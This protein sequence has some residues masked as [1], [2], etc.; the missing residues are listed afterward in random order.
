M[1]IKFTIDDAQAAAD[2]WRFN[3]GPGA[4]CAVLD[5]TPVQIRP[6]LGDFERK[7]Y[8][9][10]TLMTDTLRR[11]G[12]AFRVKYRGDAPAAKIPV[13]RLGLVRV[14][15]GGPWTKPGVPMAAR[16]R[17]TH[18]IAVAGSEIF[19]I[20]AMCVGGWMPARDW[21]HALAPWLIREAV[22]RGD[23]T[24]WPTHA[25]ELGEGA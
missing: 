16:Y 6:L 10:P 23:G 15:W 17:E 8:T 13:L 18:W 11:A 4:L 3:C 14:Q 20:N 25:L 5:M 7:G 12:R 9:N 2:E 21:T 24:W 19:D 22:P 1:K